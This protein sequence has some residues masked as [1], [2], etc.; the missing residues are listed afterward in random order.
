MSEYFVHY[1]RKMGSFVAYWMEE[2]TICW[3][4]F[5]QVI[6]APKSCPESCADRLLALY[7]DDELIGDQNEM[8]GCK[9]TT[10]NECGLAGYQSLIC[11]LELDTTFIRYQ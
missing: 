5:W 9:K 7:V 10:L 11:R 3:L 4:S 6:N 8:K 1:G 2:V